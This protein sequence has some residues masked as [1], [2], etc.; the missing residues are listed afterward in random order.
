MR[1]LELKSG[2]HLMRCGMMFVQNPRLH[3]VWILLN[4]LNQKAKQE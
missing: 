2:F 3:S 1:L 4:V